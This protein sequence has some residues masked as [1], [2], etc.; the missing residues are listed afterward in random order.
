MSDSIVTCWWNVHDGRT[1]WYQVSWT[2]PFEVCNCNYAYFFLQPF[3]SCCSVSL[4]FLQGYNDFPF[5]PPVFASRFL[6][7]ACS[8]PRHQIISGTTLFTANSFDVQPHWSFYVSLLFDSSQKFMEQVQ[9]SPVF[10]MCV[11]VSVCLRVCV[12]VPYTVAPLFWACP[13]SC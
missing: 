11:C 6:I 9:V 3:Q 13:S 1:G 5:S 12:S 7:T 8:L 10:T 4:H 2:G